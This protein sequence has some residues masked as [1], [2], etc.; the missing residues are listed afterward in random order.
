MTELEV[1][2]KVHVSLRTVR[3]SKGPPWKNA[4]FYADIASE[5]WTPALFLAPWV[6]TV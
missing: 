3:I 2:F 6:G 4:S 1:L 5:P